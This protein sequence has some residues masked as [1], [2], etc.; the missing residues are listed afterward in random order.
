MGDTRSLAIDLV[1][2]ASILYIVGYWHLFDYTRSFP[3]YQNTATHR[4]TILALAVLT[5]IS[6]YLSGKKLIRSTGDVASYYVNRFFRIYPPFIVASILFHLY[7]ISS[8]SSLVKG[9]AILAMFL[10]PAP[11][12]LWYVSML[13]LFYVLAPAL[14]ALSRRVR[15]YGVMCAATVAA[16]GVANRCSHTI[17]MRLALYFPVFA[18]GVLLARHEF[19]LSGTRPSYLALAAIASTAIPLV[20]APMIDR[21]IQLIPYALLGSWFVL[22]VAVRREG[23]PARCRGIASVSYAS[24]FMYLFH[25]PLYSILCGVYCPADGIARVGYLVA[26]CVPVITAVSWVF[27]KAYDALLAR[28][29]R[30]N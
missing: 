1:R 15:P 14:L 4:L 19:L 27:Q 26:V 30:V 25:R 7:R 2:S 6:G 3:G 13:L 11:A 18:L 8:T 29:L 12:T 28:L 10:K 21:N 16:I 23:S 20:R 5:L 24:Y 17:D 9:A 22:A